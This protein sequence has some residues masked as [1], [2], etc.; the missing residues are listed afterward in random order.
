MG[1]VHMP[2]SGTK[3]P[4]VKMAAAIQATFCDR[5]LGLIS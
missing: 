3:K 1:P 4:S 2:M 5:R